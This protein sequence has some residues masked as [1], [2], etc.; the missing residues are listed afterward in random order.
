MARPQ[1]ADEAD[2]IHI[3]RVAYNIL[4]KQSRT[5]GKEWSSR[6]GVERRAKNSSL[7]KI[8]IL[9]NV[10]KNLGLQLCIG[11]NGGPL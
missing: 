2:G 3:W 11:M 9:R 8:S 10:T 4:N 6:L 5:A 1:V 7:L